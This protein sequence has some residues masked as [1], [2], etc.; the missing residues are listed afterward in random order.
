[1]LGQPRPNSSSE[2]SA[3]HAQAMSSG[4]FEVQLCA[5]RLFNFI[6]FF[7]MFLDDKFDSSLLTLS[8]KKLSFLSISF[9]F[10]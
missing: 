6:S 5:G 1:M 8:T 4:G 10:F 3:S 9:F 2:S 7:R